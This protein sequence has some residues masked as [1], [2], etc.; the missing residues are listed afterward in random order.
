M[1]GTIDVTV[2]ASACAS[3]VY[4]VIVAQIRKPSVIAT[5]VNPAL[6]PGSLFLAQNSCVAPVE[7]LAQAKQQLANQAYMTPAGNYTLTLQ[8]A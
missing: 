6:N 3:P 8:G 1:P 2:P 5:A 4:P 7:T